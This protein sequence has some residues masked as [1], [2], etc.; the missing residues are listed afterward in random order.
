MSKNYYETLGV[1]SEVSFEELKKV[2]HKLA[3]EWHP[4]K[5]STKSEEERKIAEG[6]FKEISVAYKEILE[7][8]KNKLV[9]AEIDAKN[10]EKNKTTADTNSSEKFNKE[11]KEQINEELKR[12]D[13]ILEN[14]NLLKSISEEIL[15]KLIEIGRSHRVY[16]ENL[17]NEW[18]PY[19]NVFE[20]LYSLNSK[21]EL[22][23]FKNKFFAAVEEAI[24]K[25]EATR[26]CCY[27][28]GKTEADIYWRSYVGHSE[29]FCSNECYTPYRERWVQEEK[30]KKLLDQS[31]GEEQQPN[32]DLS[33]QLNKQEI[34]NFKDRIQKFQSQLNQL[35]DQIQTLL[36][37]QNQNS[38]NSNNNQ[39]QSIQEQLNSLQN[40]IQDLENKPNSLNTSLSQSDKQNLV[41]LKSQA[42]QLQ[43]NLQSKQTEDKEKQINIQQPPKKEFPWLWVVIPMGIVIIGLLFLLFW[44]EKKTN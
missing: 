3:L 12:V 11:E 44:K 18:T 23:N 43:K 4:D 2:Y 36:S 15:A 1:S 35:Q 39:F 29:K 24:K 6:R 27:A 16:E 26:T 17:S 22:I 21:E 7:E 41:K 42:Q 34:E 14:Y 32:P 13:E 9:V 31:S 25:A 37:N 40:Q 20:K 8:T 10:A 33:K 5:W 30:S 38:D 28:C 19:K